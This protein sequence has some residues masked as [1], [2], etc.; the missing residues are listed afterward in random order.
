MDYLDFDT[1]HTVSPPYALH[2]DMCKILPWSEERSC[3]YSVY[4]NKLN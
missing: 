1:S 2:I 4:R 3:H